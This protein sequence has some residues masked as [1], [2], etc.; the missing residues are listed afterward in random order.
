MIGGGGEYK[1]MGVG[2]EKELGGGGVCYCGV[3]EGGLFKGKE[4]V[5]VGGGDWGV[6]E[7]VYVSRLG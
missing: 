3:C 4:V 5:V 7:G 6:E 1:K 2:G